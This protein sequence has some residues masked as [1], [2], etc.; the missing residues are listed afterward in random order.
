MIGIKLKVTVDDEEIVAPITPKCAIEF[1]RHFK[2]GLPKAFTQE[3]KMEHLFW[4][5]WA[6]V[7]ATGRVI[8]PF[9][10]WLDQVQNVEMVIDNEP[11]AFAGKE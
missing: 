9:D 4:L 11:D 7:K 1:E 10:S 8:K 2:M 3:Q 5:G 6:C